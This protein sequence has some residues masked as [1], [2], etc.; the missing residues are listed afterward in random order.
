MATEF[1]ID[2]NRLSKLRD[3]IEMMVRLSKGQW[4]HIAKNSGARLA[5][6]ERLAED[7]NYDPVSS[8]LA[9][10]DAYF[11][12]HGVKRSLNSTKKSKLILETVRCERN[13]IDLV[14]ELT[15]ERRGQLQSAE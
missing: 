10:L 12:V 8:E 5:T 13:Q 15:G 3:D 2:V 11:L 1:D 6:L 9:K 4:R 14:E 7:A